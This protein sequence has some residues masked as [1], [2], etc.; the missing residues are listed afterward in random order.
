MSYRYFFCRFFFKFE[1]IE[2]MGGINSKLGNVGLVH[3]FCFYINFWTNSSGLSEKYKW[4]WY[5]VVKYTRACEYWDFVLQWF[6]LLCFHHEFISWFERWM[7]NYRERVM[8]FW[9]GFWLVVDLACKRHVCRQIHFV[10]VSVTSLAKYLWYI[11]FYF[12][13]REKSA[14]YSVNGNWGG[15]GLDPDVLLLKSFI[16]RLQSVCLFF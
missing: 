7:Y 3:L 5:L 2:F 15:F 13:K 9:N 6:C 14:M 4:A 11:W 1:Q 10:K 12:E 8:S 16:I